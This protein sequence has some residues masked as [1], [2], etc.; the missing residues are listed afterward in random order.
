[1]NYWTLNVLGSFFNDFIILLNISYW[2]TFP[3]TDL[4]DGESILKLVLLLIIWFGELQD[5]NKLEDV[6]DELVDDDDELVD[7][8]DE[9]VDVDDE[10][11]DD[12]VWKILLIANLKKLD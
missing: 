4:V 7:D 5:C 3:L 11:E 2:V 9:L 12:G 1:L 6:D 8:D 10:I